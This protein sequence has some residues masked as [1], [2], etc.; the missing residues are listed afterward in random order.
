MFLFGSV[1]GVAQTTF[2]NVSNGDISPT[3][4]AG[5]HLTLAIRPEIC[6]HPDEIVNRDIPRLVHERTQQG[7]QRVHQQAEHDAAMRRCA[8][9]EL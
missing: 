7:A 4:K 6:S 2:S 1:H 3:Q 5:T 9:D 8:S